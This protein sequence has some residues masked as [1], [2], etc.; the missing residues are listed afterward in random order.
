MVRGLVMA[1]RVGKF[2]TTALVGIELSGFMVAEAATVSNRAGAVLVSRGDKGFQPIVADAEVPP[3]GR[4]MVQPGG[5]ATITYADG[6][7]VR[8]GSGY[9]VVQEAAPCANGAREI[10]FTARMNQRGSPPPQYTQDD[11]LMTGLIVGGIV[12]IG[13]CVFWW[14]RS[15]G[16]KPASP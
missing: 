10:D 4:V 11:P 5:L 7:T 12:A 6:C 2:A 14:C 3:G 13:T 8:V 9:W 1:S 16:S 15:D